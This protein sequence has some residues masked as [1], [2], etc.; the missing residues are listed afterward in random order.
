MKLLFSI[1]LMLVSIA[2][3]VIL[4][5]GLALEEPESFEQF[6]DFRHQVIEN[7]G[8]LILSAAEASELL[9]YIYERRSNREWR[10][11]LTVV[12]MSAILLLV[13]LVSIYRQSNNTPKRRP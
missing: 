7:S 5:P 4:M 9:E 12:A 13:S 8:D 10:L 1:G 6:I 3:L 11:N 2:I